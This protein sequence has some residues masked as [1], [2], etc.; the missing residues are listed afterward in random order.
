[1]ILDEY[2]VELDQHKLSFLW[3]HTPRTLSRIRT[4]RPPAADAL[5]QE[6]KPLPQQRCEH[7]YSIQGER[8]VPRGTQSTGIQSFTSITYTTRHIIERHPQRSAFARQ[9]GILSKA[10]RQVCECVYT[11]H[12]SNPNKDDLRTIT[13]SG[14]SCKFTGSRL[15]RLIGQQVRLKQTAASYCCVAAHLHN[16]TRVCD[17]LRSDG[18]AAVDGLCDSRRIAPTTSPP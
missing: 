14:L 4:R 15:S 2:S 18:T 16:S 5:Q 3:T 11:F 12:F 1:M 9:G 17:M 7:S 10:N 8:C 13:C 6:R